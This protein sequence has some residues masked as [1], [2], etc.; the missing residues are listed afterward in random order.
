MAPVLSATGGGT[1]W[2]RDGLPDI[3]PVRLNRNRVGK[4]WA[5][6]LENQ[7]Y[8]VSGVSKISLVPPLALLALALLVMMMAWWREGR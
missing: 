2:L 5:G 8:V 6:L 4:G 7:A 3:R 1:F